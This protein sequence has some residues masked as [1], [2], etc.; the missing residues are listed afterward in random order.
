MNISDIKEIFIKENK[1]FFASIELTQNC[2]FKCKHCYCGNKDKENLKIDSFKRVIDKLYDIGC[3]VISFTGG[4]IFSYKD[5]IPLYLY[6]KEKGFL[7]DLVTNGSL[8][9]EEHIKLFKEFPPHN[10]MITMYG[11]SKE[12]YIDF[13]SRDNYDNVIHT[14]DLLKRNSFNFAIRTVVTKTL[15]NSIETFKF[16]EIAKKYKT[17]FRYDPIIFPEI[18][19]ERTPLNERLSPVKIVDLEY[20]NALRNNAW[21]KIINEKKDF[22]W[23]CR[24]GI[25][26]F[27][28]DFKG[29][30]HICGIYRDEP[31]SILDNDIDIVLR[32]LKEV[33]EKHQDIVMNNK[34]NKCSYRFMCKWCPAYST[35]YNNVIDEP[36]EYFCELAQERMRK[37]GK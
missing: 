27:A 9:N 5:F 19:G 1:V 14:L 3:L 22:E 23:Q 18:S 26:S 4:E 31:I 36:I 25:N 24:A 29:D 7:I 35:V 37:F 32:H 28:I 17:V 21:R 15:K 10:I 20:N 30:A 11:T 12:E 33:H 16:E 34:C 2:N 8:I 6:G 13:T